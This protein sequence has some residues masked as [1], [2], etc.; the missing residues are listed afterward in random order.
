MANIDIA[1]SHTAV[2]K[3]AK[4]QIDNFHVIKSGSTT[5]NF[6]ATYNV[7]VKLHGGELE[8][9]DSPDEIKIS[10]LDIVY[11][12]LDIVLDIDIPE[13]CVGGFCIVPKLN[14]GCHVTAPK[15]CLFSDKSD[16]KISLNLKGLIES[17]ISG[18][19]TTVISY[20]TNPLAKDMNPYQAYAADVLDKWR[21]YLKAKWV[22][23]DI[24]DISDTIGNILDKIVDDFINTVFAGLPD[25]AKDVLSWLL[26]GIN[27]IIRDI[28]DI[29]DDMD[30]WVSDLLGKSFGL[31]DLIIEKVA[32]HLFSK[33]PLFEIDSP[34]AIVKGELPIK[35]PVLLSIKGV[36]SDI[37]KDELVLSIDI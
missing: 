10:E 12:P 8:L 5:G 16:I 18:V 32:N 2:K 4:I 22:D 15:L 11:D 17:E 7:G 19:F 35:Q 25:W 20:F 33:N 27:D 23:I 30:E 28:L 34:Y 31:F 36:T 37:L 26:H 29:G 13:I 24:I 1:I 6:K 21:L 9:R 3:M 14:G